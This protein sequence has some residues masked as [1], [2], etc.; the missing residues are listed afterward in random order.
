MFNQ[1]T[2]MLARLLGVVLLTL[3][4]KKTGQ[5]KLTTDSLGCSLGRDILERL[6][7]MIFV[8]VKNH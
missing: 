7:G 4:I 5:N 8:C 3:Q 1:I 2:D 6:Y